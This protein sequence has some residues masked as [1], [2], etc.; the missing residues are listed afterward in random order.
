MEREIN[1]ESVAK[2][3]KAAILVAGMMG[4]NISPEQIQ[5]VVELAGGA[6]SVV[7]ILEAVWKTK[8]N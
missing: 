1:K 4:Y 7:Y 8:K 5:A 2:L 6:V 3:V